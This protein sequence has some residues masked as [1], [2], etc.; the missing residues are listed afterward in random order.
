MRRRPRMTLALTV[1]GALALSACSGP[2]TDSSA[3]EA[4]LDTIQIMVPF[5]EAQPPAKGDTIHQALEEVTGKKIELIWTPNSDY[6]E[7]TNIT[8]ASG[9][10]PHVMVIQG[11]S[12]GFIKNANAGAFWELSPYLEDYPNLVTTSPETQRNASVNGEVFGIY[13]ARDAMRT[14]VILRKDWLEAVGMEQ[15]TSVEE[16]YEIAKAFTE[17]DPDGNGADDTYG[18]IV[19]KWPG[20]INTNSPYDVISTWF[21]AGN[22]WT[23]RD[24]ELVPN[25]TT[26]E[27]YEANEYTKRFID[28]GLINGDYATMDSATW[29]EPFLNGKG[30]IIIDVHSRAAVLMALFKEQDPATFD[31]FVEISGNLASESGELFSQPTPGFSGFLAVPKTSVKTEG[32]LRAVL[33]FLND[34][35]SPEAAVLLNNGIEDVNFTLDG[36]LTVPIAELSSEGAEVAQAVKSYSQLGMNV[37]DVNYYLP[38][39][40]TEYEQEMFDKRTALETADLESA[41]QNP[42]SPYVSQTQVAKGAQL[43][44]I[45]SDAR[46]QYLAGQLDEKGLR[47]AVEQWRSTGGDD[48]I[49]EINELHDASDK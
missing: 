26:D 46:I 49:A 7:K 9:D 3:T 15:P 47:A 1:T 6:E 24:G 48:V 8:M 32:E 40:A 22:T 14:S 44:N 35:N 42:A 20:A 12:P 13:R 11:K 21:G 2:A 31:Q 18:L 5:L 25:F 34:L 19:P 36:G 43:D 23:E 4:D 28:E 29:N 39:Q 27:F 10:L 41:V 30:G 33:S 38:K 17:E 45:V 37:N 16:L